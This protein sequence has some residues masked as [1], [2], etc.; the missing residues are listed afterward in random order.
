MKKVSIKVMRWKLFLLGFFKIPMIHFVRPKLMSVDDYNMVIKIPF[1]R[2]TRNH[3]NSMYF[4]ALAVGADLAAGL[5]VYYISERLNSTLSLAFKSTSGQFLK[6]PESDV[7]F[8][9][10]SGEYI[11]K[12]IQLAKKTNERI[13]F[14]VTI[15][16]YNNENEEVAKF[17]MEVSIRVK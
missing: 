15:I 13:N 17:E 11:M 14:P 9:C 1:R 5:H 10:Q 7:F 3:L 12:E 2:R 4:G 6:R 8:H 16:A